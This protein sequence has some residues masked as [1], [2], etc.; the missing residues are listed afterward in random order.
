M[1]AIAGVILLERV[2]GLPTGGQPHQR[3][4]ARAG[5]GAVADEGV[6]LASGGG[7]AALK[8]AMRRLVGGV[9]AV[10]GAGLEEVPG[11]ARGGVPVVPEQS[12]VS[13]QLCGRNAV[14]KPAAAGVEGEQRIHAACVDRQRLGRAGVL[15][16]NCFGGDVCTVIERELFFSYRR[17]G[18]TGRMASAIWLA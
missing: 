10:A 1:V 17:D 11:D 18:V 3:Q 13:R 15:M 7:E 14:A 5:G 2:G 4:P 16:A 8:A 6:R 9:E 12:Q